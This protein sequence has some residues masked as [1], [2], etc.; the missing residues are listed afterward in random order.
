MKNIV[1]KFGGTSLA[2]ASQIRKVKDILF[3]SDERRICIVSAAGKRFIDDEKVTDLLINAFKEKDNS[4]VSREIFDR[5]RIRYK[6]IVTELGIKFDI[7]L[8]M[9]KIIDEAKSKKTVDYLASRGEYLSAKIISEFLQGCFLDT[10]DLIIFNKDRKVNYDLSYANLKKSIDDIIN[11]V[12]TNNKST[13]NKKIIIPGFYGSTIEGDIVTFSRGG[14]DITGSL[15]A[16]AVNAD[17]YEN[18]TDV[19][20]VM[21]ADPR[22]VDNAKITHYITY[23]ELRELSYMGASVLHEEAVY[24]VSSVGIPINILNTNDKDAKGTMIVSRVPSI[25]KRRIVTGIAGRKGFTAILLQKALMN[26]E[27]G[28]MAKLLK[29][30]E[31]ENIPVEHCPTGIDTISVMIKT[32]LIEGKRDIIYKSIKE[33]LSPDVLNIE[34]NISMIAIV[35]EGMVYHKRIIMEIFKALYDANV[36]VRMIDQGSSGINVI[37]GVSDSDYKKAILALSTLQDV[38]G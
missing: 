4:A 16:R 25:V 10:K 7:D 28:F 8:E 22:I 18:W 24:P 34:D 17:I 13:I 33:E 19:S 36:G 21:F 9:D 37:I 12:D 3:E 1:T 38:E 6:D 11:E 14:S 15:V 32:E 30:F 29:I 27:I 20:G 23:T 5:I 31:R 26:E 35:G 2:S